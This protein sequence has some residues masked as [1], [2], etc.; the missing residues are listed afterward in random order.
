MKICVVGADSIG[1]YVGVRLALAG[2]G[3]TLIARGANLEAIRTRGCDRPPDRGRI[4][5]KGQ[6]GLC[7]KNRFSASCRETII[8][9]R[10]AA[11]YARAWGE[12]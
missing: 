8:S 4:G 1:G 5:T 6:Y 3:V 12:S 9:R 10:G 11:S 2:E 7:T